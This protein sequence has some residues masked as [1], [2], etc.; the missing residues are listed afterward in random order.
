[1]A[2]TTM[3]ESVPVRI[4][5]AGRQG[6]AHA[7]TSSSRAASIVPSTEAV[8]APV[9]PK[10]RMV[11]SH[12][13]YMELQS[14]IVLHLSE[15]EEATGK[16]VDREELIDWYLEMR[17]AEIQDVEQLEYEKELITKLLRKLVKVCW[18]ICRMLRLSC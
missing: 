10:R 12:D 9:A 15:R 4:N 6:A 2:D 14:M 5:V 13:K 16:G 7:A 11:I 3:D 17:E 18:V 1:M 8:A